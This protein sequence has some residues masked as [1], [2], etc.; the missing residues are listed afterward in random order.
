MQKDVDEMVSPGLETA[1]Q[2]VEAECE[3]T[4]RPVGA[5][6]S[7]VGQGS[8]PEVVH[9]QA[10]YWCRRQHI[11]VAEDRPTETRR[12]QGYFFFQSSEALFFNFKKLILIW[13]GSLVLLLYVYVYPV[14][15]MVSNWRSLLLF[16]RRPVS[17]HYGHFQV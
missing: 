7:A 10:R 13:K 4:Q 6:G 16:L 8:P 2:V 9:Q 5:V 11:L 3:D 1:H 12:N 15:P 14:V 17:A